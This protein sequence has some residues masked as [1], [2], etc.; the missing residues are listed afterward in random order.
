MTRVPRRRKRPYLRVETVLEAPLWL[1]GIAIAL[2]TIAVIAQVL[3][4]L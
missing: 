4:R 2:M 1:L 3:T